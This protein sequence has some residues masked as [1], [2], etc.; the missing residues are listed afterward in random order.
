MVALLL[1]AEHH[2][3]ALL[4][5]LAHLE[6]QYFALCARRAAR[7]MEFDRLAAA[8]LELTPLPLSIHTETRHTPLAR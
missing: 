7:P 6:A 3:R 4:E 8:A 2:D 5:A 1:A